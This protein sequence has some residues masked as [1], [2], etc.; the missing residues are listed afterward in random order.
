MVGDREIEPFERAAIELLAMRLFEEDMRQ[1]HERVR[2]RD[3]AK[4]TRDDY[5]AQ[6]HLISLGQEPGAWNR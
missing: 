4:A 1:R 5:R 3:A 6:A 2:W